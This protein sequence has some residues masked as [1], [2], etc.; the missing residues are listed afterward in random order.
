VYARFDGPDYRGAAEIRA[1]DALL[2]YARGHDVAR[3]PLTDGCRSAQVALAPATRKCV[4]DL[5]GAGEEDLRFQLVWSLHVGSAIRDHYR[6]EARGR[7]V[8]CLVPR[9]ARVVVTVEGRGLLAWPRRAPVAKYVRI[10]LERAWRPTL[11]IDVAGRA[12]RSTEVEFFPDL[13]IPPPGPAA[14][15]DAWKAAVN[16]AWWGRDTALHDGRPLAILPPVPLHAVATVNGRT[17]LRRFEPRG[18]SLDLRRIPAPR[19]LRALPLVDGAPPPAGT[20]ILPGRLDVATVTAFLDIRRSH[21]HL[22][23]IVAGGQPQ[24]ILLAPSDWLTVWHVEHGLA[25]LRWRAEPAGKRY[26]G[27][28]VVRAPRGWTLEGSIA[29]YPVWRGT[30]TIKTVPP[31]THLKRV[32]DG[33]AMLCF[34]GL[35]PGWHAFDIHVDL[36]KEGRRHRVDYTHEVELPAARPHLEYHLREPQ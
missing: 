34:R 29:A 8:E 12:L 5:Q 35:R 15:T 13:L 4:I 32:C 36:V 23:A 17:V 7:R 16:R 25:H 26:P 11:R 6:L 20:A 14:R 33:V 22:A 21:P 28:M 3:V 2:V 9:G 30:G 27:T 18:E 31:D 24:R 1:G 19:E 10:H